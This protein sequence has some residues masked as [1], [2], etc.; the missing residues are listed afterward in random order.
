VSATLFRRLSLVAVFGLNLAPVWAQETPEAL[1]VT[2][3]DLGAYLAGRTAALTRDFDAAALYFGQ[4]VTADPTNPALLENVLA[5]LLGQGEVDAA[6][7]VADQIVALGIDSQFAHMVQSANA[8]QSGDWDSLLSNLEAGQTIGPLVDGLAQGWAEVGKGQMSQA[9]AAFDAVIAA[10]GLKAFGLYHKALALASV[11]DYEGADAIFALPA[12]DGMQHTRQS[13]IAH[14]QVLSLLGRND[15]AVAMIDAT[16]GNALDPS[17]AA[18]RSRLAAGEAVPFTFVGSAE[19]GLAEVY[20][21]VAMALGEDTPDAYKLIYGRIAQYLAP[22]NTEVNLLVAALLER[23][24]R[25]DLANATYDLIARDDPSYLA[26]ELGRAA[27]LRKAGQAETAVEVLQQLAESQP[28]SAVVQATLGDTLRGLEQFTEANV[29]YTRALDLYGPTDRARWFVLYTRG[30]TLHRLDQ[31]PAAE[32]D[33]RA[34]LALNPGQAQ[35]LN[36]LGYSLVEEGKNLDEALG[37]IEQAVAAQPDNGAVVDSLGWVLFQL[38]RYDESVVHMERAA[39]LEPVDAVVN[40]HLGDVYWAVGRVTEAQFQWR[41]ALSFDPEAA[42]A[43]RIRA[44]LA[45][46]LDAVLASEG[47]DPLHLAQEASP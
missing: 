6:I 1:L 11:G 12:T 3:Q 24:G 33:F 8:A 37:M 21:S 44:K 10:P 25:Y 26:A 43:L 39:A 30:I 40:D 20:Y 46:G 23:M 36:Y 13:S 47:V 35:V 18:L 34:S 5:A 38:G 45:D 4:A 31:W 17:L 16:F 22:Q 29:A 28:D 7:P 27:V 9:I 41:R 19:A 15:A 32:A 14:A 42:E 2:D